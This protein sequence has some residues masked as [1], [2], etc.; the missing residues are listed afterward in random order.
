MSFTEDQREAIWQYVIDHSQIQPNGYHGIQFYIRNQDDFWER[1]HARYTGQFSR[2][3]KL[4]KQNLADIATLRYAEKIG[5]NVEKK[6]KE[7]EASRNLLNK[8]FLFLYRK[9]RNYLFK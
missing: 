3:D 9:T 2:Y 1:V 4:E 6:I 8:L 7:I 5:R